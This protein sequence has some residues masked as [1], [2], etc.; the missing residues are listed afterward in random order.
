MANGVRIVKVP[1]LGGWFVVTGPHKT[2]IS[3]R[4]SSKFEAEEWLAKRKA[5][6]DG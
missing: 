1:L 2:P 5:A 3:G 6:R 4:F